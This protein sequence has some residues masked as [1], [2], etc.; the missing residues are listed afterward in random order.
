MRARGG[1]REA[2]TGDDGGVVGHR[3][4]GNTSEVGVRVIDVEQAEPFR[5]PRCPL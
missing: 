5:E 4:F 3:A 2:V 1:V